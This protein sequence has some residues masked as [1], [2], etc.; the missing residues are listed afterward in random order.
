MGAERD[1][2]VESPRIALCIITYRRPHYLDR[3]LGKMA[4]LTFRKSPR[5]VGQIIVVDNDEGGTAAE[6]FRRHAATLPW[7]ATY[8]IEPRR[9]IPIARNRC[10]ASVDAGTEFVVFIDDDEW[11][12]PFWLDELLETQR[13]FGADV[14]TGPVLQELQEDCARWIRDGGFF[15]C[16]RQKTGSPVDYFGNGNVLLRFDVFRRVGVFDEQ[17]ALTGGEDTH[18]SMRLRRCGLRMVWADEA[19]AYEQVPA[20]RASAG[21]L[22]R[23]AYR[24]GNAMSLCDLE[25][26][27]AVSA[28][29][30]RVFK[31]GLSI[32]AGAARLPMCV[33]R[34]RAGLVQSLWDIWRGVGMWAGV[35]GGRYEEYRLTQ[36][37]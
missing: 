14:V 34:G 2:M 1:R 18:L 37:E 9:G 13:R 25:L 27:P 4:S 26:R 8:V 5:P 35:L 33:V 22:L 32:L 17:L 7:P 15:A 30:R 11:P 31:G 23:R 36:G 6:V 28:V 3:L 29:T 12:D 10:L 24:T 20:A 21:W 19:I 16:S